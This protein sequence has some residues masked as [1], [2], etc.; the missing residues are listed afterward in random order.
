IARAST[1]DRLLATGDERATSL[2]NRW[3]YADHMSDRCAL[4]GVSN[5][6]NVVLYGGNNNGLAAIRAASGPTVMPLG[7]LLG[8][9]SSTRLVIAVV[10][11]VITGISSNRRS[12]QRHR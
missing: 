11:V 6:D 4:N 9:L 8:W 7:Q 12:R 2:A 10:L 3:H 5:A 1:A